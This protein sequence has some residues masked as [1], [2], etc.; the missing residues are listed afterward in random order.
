MRLESLVPSIPADLVAALDHSCGIRTDTDLLFFG[1][2]L[3]II[4]KLPLGTVTLSDVEK[5]TE[6]VAERASAP[7]HRGDEILA[8]MGRISEKHSR[9][10][11]GVRE[12]DDL[13]DGFGGSRVFEI[14]G[15][16]GSG[17]TALALQIVIQRLVADADSCA[18][19]ID[20]SGDFSVEKTAELVRHCDLAVSVNVLE[21][22]QVSLGFSIEEV[23]GV[24][25]A[26]RI[27]LSSS[28]TVGP[29]IRLVVLDSITPLL[30]PF[31]SAVSSQGHAMMTTFMRQLRELAQ[32]FGI[33]IIVIN[34]TSAA[35][36]FNQSSAFASTIRK[37]ALGPSFTFMTDCTLW[38]SKTKDLPD[39]EGSFSVHVAEVFR[40][41][42]TRSKTWCT[43]KFSH[44]VLS[45]TS[46]F[47]LS[48]YTAG[49]FLA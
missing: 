49:R 42:T 41:R 21:R 12:L 3:D 28:R 13:V 7:G 14:S 46:D 34:G 39:S 20:T 29:T 2:S 35:A 5:F 38:L 43:F 15:D 4:K 18:L 23:H 25:G 8:D 31:L 33:T 9:A 22:L 11:C 27:S 44:D 26:L 6:L 37:P 16:K 48:P 17:K 36:P 19:W 1:S 45:S 24:L 32:T 30:L 47:Q 40:S 10:S